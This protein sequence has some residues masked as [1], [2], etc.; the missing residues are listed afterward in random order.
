MKPAFYFFVL[1]QQTAF[2]PSFN[3]RNFSCKNLWANQTERYIGFLSRCH[4]YEGVG[5]SSFRCHEFLSSAQTLTCAGPLTR[6]LV[7]L[8][9]WSRV[10]ALVAASPTTVTSH[11]RIVLTARC[12][13][14]KVS[15]Q[16]LDKCEVF[17]LLPVLQVPFPS[18]R[19]FK[20]AEPLRMPTFSAH[21]HHRPLNR[22]IDWTWQPNSWC[23]FYLPRM[24]STYHALFK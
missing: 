17:Y 7:T 6:T 12:L 20:T 2:S 11:D 8:N 9:L 18:H 10:D 15:I 4:L 16:P 19:P 13:G 1:S 5:G 14:L 23:H 3:L 22:N 24:K 21:I